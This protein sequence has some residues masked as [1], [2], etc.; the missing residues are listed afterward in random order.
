M[1]RGKTTVH[2]K[3]NQIDIYPMGY[4]S[5]L[6]LKSISSRMISTSTLTPERSLT[7]MTSI[8]WKRFKVFPL[9]QS[10]THL[11]VW[12]DAVESI[13]ITLQGME[14]R[15]TQRTRFCSL[16]E[17]EGGSGLA[18]YRR[19][20]VKPRLSPRVRLSIRFTFDYFES[21]MEV[22]FTI[23]WHEG[24]SSHQSH[25]AEPCLRIFFDH[26]Q[27]VEAL[28]VVEP[29]VRISCMFMAHSVVV[30]NMVQ[31]RLDKRR[32]PTARKTLTT[33]AT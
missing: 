18:V 13:P 22:V 11:G 31:V 10:T 26:I 27:N 12:G 16:G 9:D 1:K 21:G 30:T 23:K 7:K 4:R 17:E 25:P 14:E 5:K 33:Q 24:K 3:T 19:G 20:W 8:S 2:V 28:L 6:T 15:W 29:K 32:L